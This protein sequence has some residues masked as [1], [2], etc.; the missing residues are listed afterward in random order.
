MHFFFQNL[1]AD[2]MGSL[3]ELLLYY[4]KFLKLRFTVHLGLKK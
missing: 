1:A 2:G 4:G 3:L